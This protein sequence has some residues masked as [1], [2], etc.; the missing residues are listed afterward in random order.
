MFENRHSTYE[1]SL[2]AEEQRK[3]WILRAMIGG[4]LLGFLGVIIGVPAVAIIGFAV[5]IPAAI[6]H[7]IKYA[8]NWI[9]KIGGG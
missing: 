6:I 8:P 5:G 9:R 3:K 4:I 7:R 2:A 1:E